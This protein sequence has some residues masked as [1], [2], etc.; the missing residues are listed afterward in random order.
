MQYT[1]DVNQSHKICNDIFITTEYFYKDLVKTINDDCDQMDTS[2]QIVDISIF[3]WE[4]YIAT[5]IVWFIVYFCLWKG[6]S[7]SS[8]VVWVTVPLPI[9]F[10][11]VMV[12]NGLT[13]ENADEGIRM[14]LKGYVNGE[15]PNI[16]EKLS[17]P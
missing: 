16:M 14:Y 8:Y 13:L 12:M 15:P 11:F 4:Q 6:V 1:L 10:I 17:E 3:G 7:S 9:F 5:L 2:T